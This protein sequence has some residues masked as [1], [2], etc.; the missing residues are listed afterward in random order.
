MATSAGSLEVGSLVEVTLLDS[1][2][3]KGYVYT[4][5]P[6]TGTLVIVQRATSEAQ[7]DDFEL[8]LVASHAV[9]SL[10][11]LSTEL[12]AADDALGA[13]LAK[14]PA[15]EVK[16]AEKREKDALDA[17]EAAMAQLNPNAP[18]DGQAI[19]DALHKTMDCTWLANAINVLDQVRIDPPYSADDCHSL[20]GNQASLD[21]IRM[22]ITGIK[23]K[24]FRRPTPAT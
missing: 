10:K 6:V 2:C 23:K 20:D 14:L 19:F 16:L 18:L 5:D 12:P 13:L 7:K 21:R 4:V 17:M 15:P 9:E 8:T 24:I 11:V 22:V 3:V 1:A